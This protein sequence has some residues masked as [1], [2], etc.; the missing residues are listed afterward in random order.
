MKTWII[1][2]ALG[3]AL[4]AAGA[5]GVFAQAGSTGGTVGKP[6]KSISG[7]A[8]AEP[9]RPHE[10]RPQKAQQ[11]RREAPDTRPGNEGAAAKARDTGSRCPL[12]QGSPSSVAESFG[13]LL[14]LGVTT[15]AQCVRYAHAHGYA[16]GDIDTYC[17]LLH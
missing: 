2:A 9:A 13:C 16:Q 5:A 15:P 14:A 3:V 8:E 10:R 4:A 6:E 1:A 11:R 7:G 17:P 12:P